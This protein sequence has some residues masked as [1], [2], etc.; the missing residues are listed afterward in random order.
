MP[1]EVVRWY[2]TVPSWSMGGND[3]HGNCVTVAAANADL[4]WSAVARGDATPIPDEEII[5]QATVIGGL[6]GFSMLQRN[7][8]WAKSGLFGHRIFAFTETDPRNRL[9]MQVTISKF[10]VADVGLMLPRAWQHE[11]VWDIG[12]GSDFTRGSWGGHCVLAAGYDVDTVTLVT[13]GRIQ[14][15]TWAALEQY[16][17][18]AYALIHPQWFLS[19]PTTPGG[20]DIGLLMDDLAEV[21]K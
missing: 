11:G 7:K 5:A 17:D 19:E 16:C 6:N 8:L 14:K 10:G 21:T 20:W 9:D 4:C 13:W 2:E 15:I 12:A 18:E 1:P 3:R